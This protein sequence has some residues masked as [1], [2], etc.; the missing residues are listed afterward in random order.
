MIDGITRGKEKKGGREDR[1]NT[2]REN[3]HMKTEAKVKMVLC[4]PARIKVG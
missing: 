2:A 1:V 3:N 4:G